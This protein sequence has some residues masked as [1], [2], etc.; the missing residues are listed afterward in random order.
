[1]LWTT[2]FTLHY[3]LQILNL[4]G[5]EI[6]IENFSISFDCSLSDIQN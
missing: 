3:N 5:A 6:L 1:M 2:Y 4:G